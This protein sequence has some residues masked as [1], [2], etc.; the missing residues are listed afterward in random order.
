V[1]FG[2][3][4]YFEVYHDHFLSV[5]SITSSAL[6]LPFMDYAKNLFELH[7]RLLNDLLLYLCPFDLF[8]EPL[9]IR[10]VYVG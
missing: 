2:W 9:S 6:Y 8:W 7:N 3:D 10:L 5:L 1:S 4:S